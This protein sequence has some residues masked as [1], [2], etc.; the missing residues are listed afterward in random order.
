MNAASKQGG[1]Q[2]LE[3]VSVI[4][5]LVD[6]QRDG[7]FSQPLE[8]QRMNYQHIP[9]SLLAKFSYN[10]AAEARGG[11]QKRLKS[12]IPSNFSNENYQKKINEAIAGHLGLSH[13]IV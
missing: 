6:A 3:P 1:A 4:V 11:Q 5:R 10:A 12:I 7:H 9:E 13:V 8:I 2:F